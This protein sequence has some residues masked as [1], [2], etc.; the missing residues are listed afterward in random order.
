MTGTQKM[1]QATN[2]KWTKMRSNGLYI[3]H[4]YT[5]NHVNVSYFICSYELK[6]SIFFTNSVANTFIL[7]TTEY[8][9]FISH[10]NTLPLPFSDL[11]LFSAGLQQGV[12]G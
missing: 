11:L 10:H 6:L 2:Q 1:Q 5:T 8:S 9:Q 7:E 4:G 12:P 3:F